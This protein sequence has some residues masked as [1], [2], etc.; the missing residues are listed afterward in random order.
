MNDKKRTEDLLKMAIEDLKD[1][2]IYVREYSTFL[3]LAVCTIN[4]LGIIL[5]SNQAFQGL[6]GYREIEAIGKKME[7][8]FLN[9]KNF[10]DLIKE[11]ILKKKP[12]LT[13]KMVL[14]TKKRKKIPVNVAISIR[15]DE[16]DN[17]IGHFIALSD[18]T[19]FEDLRKNLE[20]KVKERTKQLQERVDE[21][22]KFR[23]LTEGREL[24]MVELKQEIKKL[25][26]ELEKE[27][28]RK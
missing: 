14:L 16:E 11:K 13:R 3:P 18:I 6:T 25:K 17:F 24:R 1:I 26:E 21:L 10:K 7:D 27:K 12:S 8:L 15:R 19:A 28:G 4:T 20:R 2:E 22:E 5:N 9:K 23:K